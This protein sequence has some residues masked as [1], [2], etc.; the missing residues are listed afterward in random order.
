MFVARKEIL[1]ILYISAERFMKYPKYNIVSSASVWAN[2]IKIHMVSYKHVHSK[3]LISLKNY[4]FEL[5]HVYR[6]YINGT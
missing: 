1:L 4:I 3:L 2:Y 6:V 5:P